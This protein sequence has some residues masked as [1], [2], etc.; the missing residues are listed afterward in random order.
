MVLLQIGI[1]GTGEGGSLDVVDVSG[2]RVLIKLG[3]LKLGNSNSR[4]LELGNSNYLKTRI[5]NNLTRNLTRSN[6]VPLCIIAGS[7]VEHHYLTEESFSRL[8]TPFPETELP[9]CFCR[10]RN[11]CHRRAGTKRSGEAV[12]CRQLQGVCENA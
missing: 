12:T 2:N 6:F 9:R 11:V 3:I 7:D 4:Q 5:S 10:I 1:F 8:L